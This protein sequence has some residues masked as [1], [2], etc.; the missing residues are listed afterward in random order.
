MQSTKTRWQKV[1]LMLEF[2]EWLYCH[3]FHKAK[4]QQQVQW[5]IDVTLQLEPE[6]VEGAGETC[7]FSK[8]SHVA[9]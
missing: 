8:S 2:A 7:C 5:A 1:N 6:Q 9:I 4:A 3:N